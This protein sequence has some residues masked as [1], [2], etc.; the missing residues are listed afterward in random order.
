MYLF[1]LGIDLFKF[2]VI[3]CVFCKIVN[4][5]FSV[6]AAS[7]LHSE[8]ESALARTGTF[9]GGLYQDVKRRG[10]LYISDFRDGFNLHTLFTS[11]SLYFALF[12][13]NIAFGGLL[14][15]KTGGQLGVTEVI[16]AASACSIL[17]ALFAGQ[18]IMIIGAT[19]PILVFE[20]SIYEVSINFDNNCT[21]KWSLPYPDLPG[22]H[23]ET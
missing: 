15:D 18:P 6:F 14:E 4:L 13:T 5:H 23:I 1:K 22:G 7:S 8:G 19:G 17:F 10:K 3:A 2:L 20:Q 9:F 16:F 11:L 21:I 12:A